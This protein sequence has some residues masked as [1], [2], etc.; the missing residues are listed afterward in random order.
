MN[1]YYK[2]LPTSSEDE[3]WGM[4]V[5]NIGCNKISRHTAYPSPEHPAHHYFNWSKGR[6]LDEYQI[7]YITEGEGVFESINCG[8]QLIKQGTIIFLFPGEWHRFKPNPQTGWDE[9]WVGFKGDIIE[10][11]TRQNFIAR[12]N[13]VVEIG[14]Q[15]TIVQLFLTILDKAKA[16]RAGYQPVV[17]GIVMYLLGEIYSLTKL[18]RFDASD[19]T[20]AIINKARVIFRKNI[21]QA[22][23]ME[24]LAADLNVS[25]AWFRKAFKTYTGIAPNQYFLQLKIEKAKMLLLDQSKTIKEIAFSLNFESAFYFSK[26]FKEK[27]GVS[28]EVYRK[29]VER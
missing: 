4:H 7:I 23:S 9:F 16:E 24:Q 18:Q 3:R 6:I 2:Y 1:N 22:I 17:S 20:E 15:E 21:D 29:G 26:L 27:I 14:L 5:L 13:A 12:E 25:Y 11:I 10:N 19:G 8:E 28:P